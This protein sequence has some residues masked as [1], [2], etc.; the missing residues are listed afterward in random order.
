[1]TG[2]SL[3][4]RR[5]STPLQ[6]PLE[7]IHSVGEG[8]RLSDSPTT[9]LVGPQRTGWERGRRQAKQ[10]TQGS[11]APSHG[12]DNACRAD[13]STAGG[14]PGG[15]TS[16]IGKRARRRSTNWQGHGRPR[17]PGCRGPCWR[18]GGITARDIPTVCDAGHQCRPGGCC[19]CCLGLGHSP[20]PLLHGVDGV[21]EVRGWGRKGRG[22][23][24]ACNSPGGFELGN[25]DPD[26]DP[27]RAGTGTTSAGR[28]A[29][30]SVWFRATG[31]RGASSGVGRGAASAECPT[32]G[33]TT[34]LQCGCE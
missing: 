3:R 16:N 31:T 6:T 18:K 19:S 13:G 21:K 34:P 1:M 17:R 30:A 11:A 14:R 28:C 23:G 15:T 9:K 5:H 32:Y 24:R 27:R 10:A 2:P 8:V 12:T 33:G 20:T 4:E 7:R 22:P 29:A 25:S 26:W